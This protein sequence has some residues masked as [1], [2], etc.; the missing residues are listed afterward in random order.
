MVGLDLDEGGHFLRRVFKK[1][2]DLSKDIVDIFDVFYVSFLAGVNCCQSQSMT[3]AVECENGGKN[4][5]GEVWPVHSP[6]KKEN[7]E[8]YGNSKLLTETVHK[9]ITACL[10]SL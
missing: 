3:D 10:L 7:P 2:P 5:C 8:V 4:L 1:L 9:L 6:A